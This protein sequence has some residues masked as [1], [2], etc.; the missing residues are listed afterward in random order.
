MARYLLV[1]FDDNDAADRMRAQIDTA[2]E[3][4]KGM[5]VAGLFAVPTSWC[6]C[7]QS[8]G[9]YANEVV[10]GSKLGWW[11]HKACR[12]ARVGTHNL[13]NLI[14]ASERSYRADADYIEFVSSVNIFEMKRTKAENLDS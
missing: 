3:A 11:V 14:R 12:K 13:A 7:P 4:G 5:R 1:E 10:R 2:T 9:Y 8:D 6:I